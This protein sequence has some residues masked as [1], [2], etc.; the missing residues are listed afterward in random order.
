MAQ[1]VGLRNISSAISQTFTN[2]VML[3][4]AIHYIISLLRLHLFIIYE[5]PLSLNH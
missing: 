4:I 1:C 5:H 2:E 3:L